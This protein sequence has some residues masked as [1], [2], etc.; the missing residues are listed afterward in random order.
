MKHYS[1]KS[2]VPQ[3]TNSHWCL[4]Q[5]THCV[6]SVAVNFA[7]YFG[8]VLSYIIVAIPIFA[9]DYDDKTA[10]EIAQIISAV[11]RLEFHNLKVK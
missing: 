8:S 5:L 3:N 1:F 6:V 2:S 4:F 10:S 7:D 9:G 11:S